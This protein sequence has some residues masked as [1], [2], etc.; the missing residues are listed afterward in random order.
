MVKKEKFRRNGGIIEIID[1]NPK[2]TK[3]KIPVLLAPGW[4]GTIKAFEKPITF[5]VKEG[6]RVLSLNHPREGGRVRNNGKYPIE[7]YR[8]AMS[9]LA[10]IEK[11]KLKKVDII[12][13]SEGCIN[14][15]I[16]ATLKPDSFRNIVLVNPGGMVGKTAFLKLTERFIKSLVKNNIET[17]I[18]PET[19]E[20]MDNTMEELLGYIKNN[21]KRAIEEA[22]EIARFEIDGML[23][24]LKNQGVKIAIIHTENDSA[25]PMNEVK[26]VAG[27]D[28]I[29][30]FYPADGGHFEIFRY[31]EKF[32]DIID[33]ALSDLEK[34]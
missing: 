8:K 3:S 12:G 33:L 30:R 14:A 5:L 29:D 22:L 23:K 34:K 16:A 26:R 24:D 32:M 27:L 15:I 19:K 13:Y 9:L 20:N 25:F 6:R 10:V 18:R 31:P 4:G 28:Q 7:E 11:K 21:P 17:F 2:K 1:V